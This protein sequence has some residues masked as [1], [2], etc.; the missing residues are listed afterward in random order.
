MSFGKRPSTT[1]AAQ[2]PSEPPRPDPHGRRKVF[3]DEI[4]EGEHGNLLRM[5][6]MSPDDESNL[7]PNASSV[8]AEI[9]RRKAQHD[10]AFAEAQRRVQSTLAS[11]Q[12]R[13]FS[14]IPD[15]VW[16]SPAGAFLMTNLGLYP[17]DTWN[18]MYLAADERTALTLDLALHPGGDVPAFVQASQE[19]MANAQAHLERVRVHV[20]Q[21]QNWQAFTE[22]QDDV[23][24]RLKGIAMLFARRIAETWAENSPNRGAPKH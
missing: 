2:P 16:N 6:G 18:I 21:T 13:P 14:L 20:M 22:A 24:E 5:L 17:Y 15:A 1:A 23:R 7:V 4:W 9:D 19:F 8:N 11:A 12:I 10:A 3:G